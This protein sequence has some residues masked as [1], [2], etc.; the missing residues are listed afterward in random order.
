[1]NEQVDSS[2]LAMRRQS[3]DVIIDDCFFIS[4]VSYFRW[5]KIGGEWGKIRV[6]ESGEDHWTRVESVVMNTVHRRRKGRTTGTHRTPMQLLRHVC[7]FVVISS[8]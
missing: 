6:S 1:M 7:P 5:V 8:G 2:R 3:K 4:P